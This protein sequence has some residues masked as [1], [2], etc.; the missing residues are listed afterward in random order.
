MGDFDRPKA[1]NDVYVEEGELRKMRD[2]R[3]GQIKEV[4]MS[5]A[6]LSRTME[7]I[8]KSAEIIN[9][10]T[11]SFEMAMSRFDYIKELVLD[12]AQFS[13]K[14]KNLQIRILNKTIEVV[15]EIDEFDMV[16]ISFARNHY[17][18]KAKAELAKENRSSKEGRAKAIEKAIEI[19]NSGAKYLKDDHEAQSY[20]NGLKEELDSL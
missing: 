12:H 14:L 11:T 5:L 4:D 6:A 18:T 3:T 10:P 17:M 20:I 9:Q 13:P 2:P 19:M 8:R 16:R 15:R 7:Q 1:N